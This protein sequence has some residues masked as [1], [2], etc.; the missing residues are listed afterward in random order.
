M[1][2]RGFII[3]ALMVTTLLACSV[4]A[5]PEQSTNDR[6]AGTAVPCVSIGN[7]SA[8]PN[9]LIVEPIMIMNVV[10]PAG[11]GAAAINLTYN[12]LVV[13]VV[14]ATNGDFDSLTSGIHNTDGWTRF[15]CY[16]TGASG[17]GPG[18]ARVADITFR[19]V[20]NAGESSPLDIQI[21][22]LTNNSGVDLKATTVPIDG[23]FTI[24]GT[25]AAAPEEVIIEEE[26]I[27]STVTAPSRAISPEVDNIFRFEEEKDTD[28]GISSITIRAKASVSDV[29]IMVQKLSSK[30]SLL[31]S[32]PDSVYGY[33]NISA[34]VVP[35]E[36]IESARMNFK[37]SKLWTDTNE[38]D[39]MSIRLNR[40]VHTGTGN[41]ES[42]QTTK[43]REDDPHY[44]YYFSETTGLSLFA[45]TGRS[46]E[47][48]PA[49]TPTPTPTSTPRAIPVPPP[50]KRPW[51]LI[52]GIIIAV[53]VVGAT[54]YYFY[55]KKKA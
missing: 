53:I 13:E 31:P 32:P 44:A 29:Q 6:V 2:N 7:I 9:A 43:I 35:G 26:N 49:L 4:V 11:L 30:P 8:A 24:T 5:A 28:I 10:D 19:A 37:V 20:G 39:D 15:V 3:S 16:Q 52:I 40:Y 55:T 48:T 22:T 54:A 1:L 38:I 23:S 46:K 50:G 36:D 42:L 27:L 25:G 33:F 18:D 47:T 12:P 17:A 21:I 45:I 41:W 51:G 14:S 34:T